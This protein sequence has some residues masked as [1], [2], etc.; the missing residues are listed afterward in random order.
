[1]ICK[2]EEIVIVNNSQ[3]MWTTSHAYSSSL[4]LLSAL[5]VMD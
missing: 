4:S 3:F 1:L 5:L 2:P